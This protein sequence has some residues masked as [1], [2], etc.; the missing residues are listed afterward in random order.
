MYGRSFKNVWL[1][2]S[3]DIS[4]QQRFLIYDFVRKSKIV[5][6][7]S[8]LK[9]TIEFKNTLACPTVRRAGINDLRFMMIIKMLA[10]SNITS[11]NI[12]P[13]QITPDYTKKAAS[14]PEQLF[15]YVFL[16]FY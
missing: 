16:I 4:T 5:N 9:R 13:R 15:H 11:K 2:R 6:Q 14:F 12:V 3:R 1:L 7:Y 8:I 10:V